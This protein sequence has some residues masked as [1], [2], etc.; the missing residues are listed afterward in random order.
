[1]VPVPPAEYVN[2]VPIPFLALSGGEFHFH[3]VGPQPEVGQ[4]AK[5]LKEALNDIGLGAKTTSGYG[6]FNAEVV[7]GVPG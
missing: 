6:Y 5:Q 4:A 2:P 3:L 1:M 7:Q